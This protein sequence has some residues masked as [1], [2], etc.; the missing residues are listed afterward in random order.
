MWHQLEL[1]SELESD[2]QDT[3]AWGRMWLGDLNAG[4]TQLVWFDRSNNAGAI[5]VKMEWSVLEEKSFFKVLG[6][7]LSLSCKLD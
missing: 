1:A 6:L 5:D 7:S 2:L 3:I 4:K